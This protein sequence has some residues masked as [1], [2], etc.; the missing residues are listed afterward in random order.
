MN[1]DRYNF[2][3]ELFRAILIKCKFNYG[4]DCVTKC[5]FAVGHSR[6][7]KERR[8]CKVTSRRWSLSLPQIMRPKFNLPIQV[9]LLPSG[10]SKQLT[11][12]MFSETS[13]AV[14]VTSVVRAECSL[15]LGRGCNLK[16]TDPAIYQTPQFGSLHLP[17]PIPPP[18]PQFPAWLSL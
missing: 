8:T 4:M 12:M 17:L 15:G 6:A 7:R 9:N 16:P 14:A 10:P 2:P 11:S 18:L 1:G 13:V 5:H 3:P